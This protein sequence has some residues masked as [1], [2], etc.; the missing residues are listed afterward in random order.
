[1]DSVADAVSRIKGNLEQI[2]PD[3]VIESLSEGL[4][5]NGRD[6]TLTPAVTVRLALRR[7]LEGGTAVSHLRHLTGLD[8]HDSSYGRA[9]QR[10][11]ETF[12][13]RLTRVVT[14]RLRR[15]RPS[16]LWHGH[17]VAVVDGTGL[18]MPDTPP[19]QVAFGQPG[20]QKPGC[21]YPVAHLLALFDHTTGHLIETHLDPL[22]THDLVRTPAMHAAMQ[23]G[24][25]L[26]GDRAFGSF[27]HFALLQQ[28]GLHGLFRQHQ[29][30]PKGT[31]PDR[32]VRYAKPKLKPSWMS[33]K[34]YAALPSE[35][36][37]REVAVQVREP[38]RRVRN[39]VLVTSLLEEA[40]YPARALA[41]LYEQRWQIEV[42]LRHLKT[43]LNMEVLRSHSLDGVRKEVQAFALAYNLVRQT[44]ATAGERQRVPPDRISFVDALRWLRSAQPDE[45]VPELI[46]NPPRPG[47]FEPRVVKRRPK[48]HKLMTKPRR[49]LKKALEN[50]QQ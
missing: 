26:L 39:L 49:E 14:G 22:R 34:D 20:G 1:M 32:L 43:T 37:L 7:C 23:P 16:P 13:T 38:G 24:D 50:Q 28:R 45:T 46:V 5:L 21:G 11:P 47:R 12:F 15:G 4:G 30:R 3:A 19:L 17:R 33:P 9:V 2:L 35:L 31:A 42:N 41:K 10:L 48:P 40:K 29:R 6:C 8:F 36:T 25:L 18:S 44:M 27:A